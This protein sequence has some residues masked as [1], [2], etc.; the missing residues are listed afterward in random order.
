MYSSKI[1]ITVFG[2]NKVSVK[3]QLDN[4]HTNK[5]KEIKLTLSLIKKMLIKPL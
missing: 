2:I 3:F 4:N 5:N 1:S